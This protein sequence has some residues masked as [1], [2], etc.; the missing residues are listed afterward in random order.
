[1]QY[2]LFPRFH[3]IFHECHSSRITIIFLSPIY[4]TDSE[5]DDNIPRLKQRLTV[6]IIGAIF[7][8][9]YSYLTKLGSLLQAY[10]L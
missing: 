8:S 7:D 2:Y 10:V 1:M 9:H 5:T 4:L 6:F 3:P